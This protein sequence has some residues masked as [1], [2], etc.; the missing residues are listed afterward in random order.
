MIGLLFGL[1]FVTALLSIPLFALI[2][3]S[4]AVTEVER[5]RR[6]IESLARELRQ[7][8][9]AGTEAPGRTEAVRPITEA[10]PT[11]PIAPA[12][13]APLP[14]VAAEPRPI[15]PPPVAAVAEA[16][17]AEADSLEARIGSRWLLYVGVGAIVVAAAYFVKLA[18]DSQWITESMRVAIGGAAGLALAW[19]GRR[20]VRAGYPLYGQ[21]LAGGGIAIL[22]L[23]VYA[24]FNF[25]ALVERGVAFSLMAAVTGLAAWLADAQRAQG[26][27]LMA[28]GG[29]FLTPFLIGGDTDAQAALFGYDAILVAGTAALASRR[30]WPALNLVSYV[31]AFVTIT[32]WFS[33]FYTDAAYLRTVSFL[34]VFC[35]LFCYILARAWRSTHELAPIVGLTLATAPVAYYATTVV[36]LFPHGL[37]LLVFFVA[38]TVAGL[39]IARRVGAAWGRLA[40]WLVVAVPLAVWIAEAAGPSWLSPALT[41]AIAI[42]ALHLGSQIDAASQ[43]TGRVRPADVALLHLTGLGLFALVYLLLEDRSAN[44]VAMSAIAISAAHGALAVWAKR[45][46]DELSLHF[47]AV[48]AALAATAVAL[49]ADGAWA[50]VGLS[51]E[52]A[53]LVAIGLRTGRDWLRLG[54]SLL[55]GLA[56]LRFMNLEFGPVATDHRVLLNE[57]AAAALVLIALLYGL[58][59]LHRREM[60]RL[61][62]RAQ[63]DSDYFLLVMNGVICAGVTH[64]I[65]AFWELREGGRPAELSRMASLAT[66]WALQAVGII[67]VGLT[68][69]RDWLRLVGGALLLVPVAWLAFSLW[70]DVLERIRPLEGYVLLVNARAAAALI[71]VAALGW[72]AA[73]HYRLRAASEDAFGPEI[74]VAVL[75]AAILTLGL[76]SAEASAFWYLRDA[77]GGDARR[78]FHF[79]RELTLSILW[80]GSA[81]ALVAAG[82]R[83][84]YAPIRYLAIALF[85]AT[86]VKV[87]LV[88]LAQLERLYRVLSVMALGF[89]MLLASYL[90]QRQLKAG[91][92]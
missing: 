14:P 49:W 9:S 4:R 33:R 45:F 18:F 88:D 58:A 21:M 92:R 70:A 71:V 2:R 12:A 56:T 16:A 55:L 89:L 1:L 44:T 79:A 43:S 38:A 91:R 54:G 77:A 19:L 15:P 39:V 36:L 69:Q 3:A 28:V 74:A 10:A 64:E 80:A 53:A 5:L 61:T 87:A 82:I 7:L 24:A 23:S 48:A 84:R 57:S 52:A 83:R 46:R 35:A 59:R 85:V 86:M 26:L 37:A 11:V 13:P 65:H 63:Q 67:R 76:L 25:Y 30:D 32:G 60:G 75:G 68:R 22:Y 31:L 34:T 20:F 8:H 50:L 17:P 73:V 41:V 27:A 40:I 29:G 47:G 6:E 72:L 42:A 90:Y 51:V 62:A 78:V 81:A 66:A